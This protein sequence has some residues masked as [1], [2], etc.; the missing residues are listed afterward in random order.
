M[1]ENDDVVAH[2]GRAIV[3]PLLYHAGLYAASAALLKLAGFAFFLWV[4]RTFSVDDYAT[5][6]LL[7]ALQTALSTFGL[8]GIVEAVVGLLKVHRS[9]EQR[10][11]L[12]AAANNV[13][14]LTLASSILLGLLLFAIYLRH[15]DIPFEAVVGALASGSLLAYSS[16]QS[17]I[18]RLEEKHL[19][20]LCFNFAIPLAGLAGSLAA[21]ALEKTV[22]SFFLGSTVGLAIALFA[23]RVKGIG[24]YSLAAT[25]T[26]GRPILSRVAP[27]IPVA[28]LGWLA[29]Y[30]NNYVI[31]LFF[32]SAEVAR[33]TFAFMLSSTMQLF[34]TATNQ[35]WSP[36]FY[37]II[38]DLPLDQVE[39]K[40][41]RFFRLQGIALGLAGGILI[42]SFPS[43]LTVLGGNLIH[44]RSMN[45]ELGLLVLSY[46][47]LVP[48]WHCANY[49][50]A[51]DKGPEMMRIHVAASV[52]GIVALV[53]FMLA[54]GPLGIYI[55]F[56]AQMALRSAGA[57]VV[58]RRHWPVKVS[59]DGIVTGVALTIIGFAVS[60]SGL[61]R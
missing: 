12:F 59:L 33:F 47:L 8:V 18:V 48:W 19:A 31:Q 10:K 26:D 4:A 37:R 24:C 14:I 42:A 57:L 6:G 27:F 2:P 43:V 5:W 45:L 52:T 51:Y 9:A 11:E 54:L 39:R 7:Y 40:N 21:F 32:D 28:F 30:G 22:Q 34:A 41:L 50:L 20:S 38:H 17:Q 13:F 16:L 36:R 25:F 35:V 58:A 15:G 23:A 60:G 44:Y 1:I 49:F 56:L 55:G 53:L 61:G 29:G 46:V 3:N